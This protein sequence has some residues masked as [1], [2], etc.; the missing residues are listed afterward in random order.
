M[1][2]QGTGLLVKPTGS[3]ARGTENDGP[4][5][6]GENGTTPD[7]GEWVC[8]DS[9]ATGPQAVGRM[10]RYREPVLVYGTGLLDKP[11]PLDQWV[12]TAVSGC[13]VTWLELVGGN[14]F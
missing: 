12:K 1:K 7:A 2:P 9:P 6:T 3:H 13:E 4:G 8:C 10:V 11:I 5:I 14:H